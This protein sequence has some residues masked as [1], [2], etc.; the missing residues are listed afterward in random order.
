MKDNKDLDAVTAFKTAKELDSSLASAADYQTG[1]AYLKEKRFK[2]AQGV[3]KDV[4]VFDPNS[5]LADFSNEYMNALKRKEEA[6]KPLRLT[7][8][9]YGEY[10]SN[11]VLKPSDATV[12]ANVTDKADWREV[13]TFLGEY[14]Q[15]ITER[16]SISPQYS[17]YRAHQNDL[18]ILNVTSHT[19]TVIPNYNIDKGTIGLPVGYNY[20]EVGE[21]KYLTTLSAT[22]TLNYMMGKAEM[23]QF[24]FQYQK[25]DFSRTPVIPDEDRD[26]NYFSGGLGLYHFFKQNTGFFG[27]HYGLNKDFTKGV[28]W[29]Y[30]GNRF[31]ATVMYPFLKR[32]KASISGEAFLQDFDDINTVFQVVRRDQVYTASGFLSYNFW[33]EAELQFRYTYVKDNSNIALYDYD[34]NVYSLGLQYRY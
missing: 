21:S 19:F 12:A 10:D 5:N 18:G 29:K 17:L 26:S 13:Y 30:H 9:A 22:P 15:K 20:T 2:E 14:R 25:N 33:K 34:R 31:D 6:E 8:G 11:V 32:F 24:T 7:F 3:F 1:L 28:D 4:I 16:F 27:I 23:A